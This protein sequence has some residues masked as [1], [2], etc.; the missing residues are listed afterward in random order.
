MLGMTQ[1]DSHACSFPLGNCAGRNGETKTVTFSKKK[2]VRLANQRR[3]QL[4]AL[5][6][7]LRMVEISVERQIMVDGL[8]IWLSNEGT[9]LGLSTNY[10]TLFMAVF[11]PPPPPRNSNNR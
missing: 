10:L 3:K 1:S 8:F 11:Y 7:Y 2:S 9:R 5:C 6:L 4:S